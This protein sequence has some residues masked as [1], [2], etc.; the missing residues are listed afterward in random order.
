MK[1]VELEWP[2]ANNISKGLFERL[3]VV[4][5]TVDVRLHSIGLVPGFRWEAGSPSTQSNKPGLLVVAKTRIHLQGLRDV[6]NNGVNNI[7]NNHSQHHESPN[8]VIEEGALLEA[9]EGICGESS[10]G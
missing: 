8:L 5:H 7:V 3:A 2:L 9:S 1:I 4:V 10:M 6:V